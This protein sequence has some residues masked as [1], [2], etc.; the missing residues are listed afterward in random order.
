MNQK[1]HLSV[2]EL[3]LLSIEN[4]LIIFDLTI[5]NRN[6]TNSN[7]FNQAQVSTFSTPKAQF[8]PRFFPFLA[9]LILTLNP[10]M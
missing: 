2:L 1:C 3:T 8:S 6:L 9:L 4:K 10:Y 7:I 5:F